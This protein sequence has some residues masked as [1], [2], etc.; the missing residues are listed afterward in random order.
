MVG[1]RALGTV[2]LPAWFMLEL[3]ALAAIVGAV[4]ALWLS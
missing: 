2:R 4:I 3:L 1:R